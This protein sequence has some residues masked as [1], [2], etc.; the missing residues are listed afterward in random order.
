MKILKISDVGAQYVDEKGA[1]QPIDGLKKEDLLRL[2]TL[3]LE[4][5]NVEMDEYSEGVIKNQAHEI[6]YKNV[7]QK[8]RDLRMRRDEFR[9]EAARKYLDSYQKYCGESGKQ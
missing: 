1:F 9:D 6:I 7:F 4:E 3:V 5:P 8:L 2:A